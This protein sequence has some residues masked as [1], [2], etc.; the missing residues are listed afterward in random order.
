MSSYSANIT[1]SDPFWNRR[2]TELQA[3]FEQKAMASIFFTFSYPDL[4]LVDLHRL[5]PGKSSSNKTER[6]KNVL[7]NQHLV[8]WYFSFRLNKFLEIV[9]DDILQSDWR[10]HRYEWQQ[11]TS[12]H[13]HGC[14]RFKNDPDI[15]KL[16]TIVYEGKKLIRDSPFPIQFHGDMNDP[17]QIEKFNNQYL[18]IIQKIEKSKQAEERIITYVD[19]LV[20]AM[21]PKQFDYSQINGVPDPHPC[22]IDICLLDP[23]QYDEDYLELVNC[24]QRHVCRTE[25]YCKSK[26]KSL[27]NK[28]RFG[29]PF[30]LLNESQIVFNE[31]KTKVHA[32][33]ELKRN[34]PFMN[35]HI[36]V[37]T[38]E[39]R[40]NTDTQVILDAKAAQDYIAKYACKGIR[41]NISIY[42]L[43]IN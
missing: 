9:F 31:T 19:T 23:E 28:C 2:R 35:P 17:Y 29:F 37:V 20:T 21:N 3:T 13:A 18:E 43:K 10:W 12:I 25:G 34:D 40:G 30:K 42:Y 39:W 38:H 1:G 7:N 27:A 41:K 33:I 32:E 22:C 8:D 5:M 26:K 24:V 11:R 6:Y 36:R 16:T 4:H 14:A 15:I